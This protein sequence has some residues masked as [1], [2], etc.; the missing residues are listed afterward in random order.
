[1]NDA[2]DSELYSLSYVT[3]EEVARWAIS[4]G[5]NSIGKI[6]IKAAYRLV[7]VALLITCG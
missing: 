2:I 3:V 5:R 1:M 6:D 7:P 4:M